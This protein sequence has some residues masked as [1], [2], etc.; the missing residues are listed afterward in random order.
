MTECFKV[1]WKTPLLRAQVK[2]AFVLHTV[3]LSLWSPIQSHR[4]GWPLEVTWSNPLLETALG[5]TR[6]R[7]SWLCT[8]KPWRPPQMGR[9]HHVCGWPLLVLHYLNKG[10]LYLCPAQSSLM[11]ICSLSPCCVICY[12]FEELGFFI[13]VTVLKVLRSCC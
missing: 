8:A 13:F 9:F 6:L 1:Q 3:H 4:N 10:K 7:E 5:N 2:I 12:Y 11:V